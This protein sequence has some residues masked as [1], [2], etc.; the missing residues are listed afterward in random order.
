MSPDLNVAVMGPNAVDSMMLW[1]NYYGRPFHTV[2]VLDG[3]RRFAPSARYIPGCTYTDQAV[4]QQTGVPYDGT[5]PKE[6][7]TAESGRTTGAD[8][9]SIVGQASDADVVILVFHL[10][11]KGKR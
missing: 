2:T 6:V 9:A 1:G 3:I 8:V 4:G 7:K 10:N 5:Q 11:W